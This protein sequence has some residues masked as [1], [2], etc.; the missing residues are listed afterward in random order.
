MECG[1]DER[2]VRPEY[3]DEEKVRKQL[4]RREFHIGFNSLNG[5]SETSF[6]KKKFLLIFV[7]GHNQLMVVKVLQSVLLAFKVTFSGDS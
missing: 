1:K 5:F 7:L 6:F 2:S 3:R 4:L